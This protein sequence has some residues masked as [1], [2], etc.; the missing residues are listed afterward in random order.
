MLF[1]V[2]TS[3]AVGLA[4]LLIAAPAHVNALVTPGSGSE[5]G[6]LAA[7]RLAGVSPNHHALARRKTNTHKK[8]QRCQQRPVSNST[9]APEQTGTANADV[10]VGGGDNNSNN[11]NN[12]NNNNPSNPTT[13]PPAP[14]NTGTST[15]PPSGNGK[16]ILAWPNGQ[17][18]YINQFF[19]GKASMYV[20][21]SCTHLEIMLTLTAGTI[22]GR[23]TR[24]RAT[25]AISGS[26][27]CFGVTRTT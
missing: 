23:H 4:G 21:H 3:S 17:E 5:L 15:P 25:L 20:T 22:T 26:V 7:R 18:Q 8:R 27:P 24:L 14:A 16:L 11:N 12:N 19:T 2:L 13:T 1:S 9:P 10:Y 6:H